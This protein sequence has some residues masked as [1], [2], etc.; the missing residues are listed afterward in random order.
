MIQR[1]SDHAHG[2]IEMTQTQINAAKIVLAKMVPDMTK[3][4]HEHSG[5]VNIQIVKFAG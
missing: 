5:Q 3:N 4:E 1:L 2:E